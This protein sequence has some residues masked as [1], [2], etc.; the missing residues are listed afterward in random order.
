[1]IFPLDS[2]CQAVEKG[3]G[4]QEGKLFPI[5]NSFRIVMKAFIFI[6]THL[7]SL[8]LVSMFSFT[9]SETGA[10]RVLS[11]KSNNK[12]LRISA[13]ENTSGLSGYPN[14]TSYLKD[15]AE[16]KTTT[17]LLCPG[18]D[19][20]TTEPLEL[21]ENQ[22][23]LTVTCLDPLQVCVWNAANGS[24]I[25][26]HSRDNL[27]V[28]I[29]GVT[30]ESSTKSSIIVE[31]EPLPRM[32]ILFH[33]CKWKK[34][35]GRA[36]IEIIARNATE[37]QPLP[38]AKS[39][40]NAEVNIT[41]TV[42]EFNTVTDSV[43]FNEVANLRVE[44][45]VFRENQLEN[46]VIYCASGT[47]E[48]S[49]CSMQH[50]AVKTGAV[51]V[52]NESSAMIKE[53]CGDN[54][55][56]SSLDCNGT[57]YKAN[58]NTPCSDPN[59]CD[60][61]C[62]PLDTCMSVTKV[63]TTDCY[64]TWKE[65]TS[66]LA[67]ISAGTFEL[68]AG[69][70]M[71]VVDPIVVISSK[72]L[73]IKC[74]PNG[75]HQNDCSINGGKHHFWLRNPALE[76]KFQGISFA[77]ST[78]VSIQIELDPSLNAN[79]TF[80][81]CDWS[82]N[83]GSSTMMIIPNNSSRQ[84]YRQDRMNGILAS[85]TI[86]DCYF[87]ENIATG[88]LITDESAEL[89]IKDTTFSENSAG[90][91]IIGVVGGKIVLE[92]IQLLQ[93][94]LGVG[95]IFVGLDNGTLESTGVCEKN[96]TAGNNHCKGTIYDTIGSS[97]PVCVELDLC[98]S[99]NAQGC[100]STWKDLSAAL[101]VSIAGFFEICR[102]SE[103][104]LT[105]S[106]LPIEIASDTDIQC[107]PN[108]TS[109]DEC[110]IRGGQFQFHI[111]DRAKTVVFRGIQFKEA[112]NVS[113][114]VTINPMAFSSIYFSDCH[115]E[116]NTG[117]S[118]F[119]ILPS[120]TPGRL[121]VGKNA[122][123]ANLTM[124]RS[125]FKNNDVTES[126]VSNGAVDLTIVNT[127]FSGNTAIESVIE[128]AVENSELQMVTLTENVAGRGIV[129][130][131]YGAKLMS[132]NLCGT[133]NSA[134]DLNCTGVL[135]SG[136]PSNSCL[137]GETSACQ[138]VCK[139]IEECSASP[140]GTLTIANGDEC[141]S[142]WEQLLFSLLNSGGDENFTICR[143]TTFELNETSLPL[144]VRSSDITLRCGV[145]G[146][147]ENNCTIVG[148]VQ[149]LVVIG[150]S[151]NARV[152]GI[153]F[154]GTA[155]STAVFGLGNVT[156]DAAFYDC[157]FSGHRGIAAF[158]VASSQTFDHVGLRHMEMLFSEIAHRILQLSTLP[159]KMYPAMIVR[160]NNCLFNANFVNIA[161]LANLGGKVYVENC[162]F[163]K[164][165][166]EIGGVVTI[167]SGRLSL[168]SSCFIQNKGTLAGSVLLES[169]SMLLEESEN[170]GTKN[171]ALVDCNGVIFAD[172]KTCVDFNSKE[173][174]VEI[175]GSSP[176]FS[177]TN[178]GS[179]E[180]TTCFSD[181]EIFYS[182]VFAA[183]GG[184]KFRIC[185]DTTFKLEEY[186]DSGLVPLFITASNIDI[187]CG[188]RQK[189]CRFSGGTRH[190]EFRGSV[191]NVHLRGL[192][193]TN[194]TESS[195]FASLTS[196]MEITFDDCEWIHNTGN[197]TI[198]A[199]DPSY[200]GL[201]PS[202]QT[203]DDILAGGDDSLIGG[204][205]LNYDAFSDLICNLCVF[206]ANAA[207]GAIIAI[208]GANLTLNAVHFSNNNVQGYLIVADNGMVTMTDSCLSGNAPGQGTFNGAISG[209]G[210]FA[211]NDGSMGTSNLKFD[212]DRCS[213]DEKQCYGT[214][215]D[216]STA[217]STAG[218]S[219]MIYTLC[220]NTHLVVGSTSSIHVQRK[221]TQFRCGMEG[222]S[223]GNC[224]V[225]GGVTQ[226]LITGTPTGVVFAG[227]TFTGAT[228]ASIY[229]SGELAAR[230]EI[231]DCSF[232]NNTGMASILLYN[233]NLSTSGRADQRRRHSIS[234][235]TPPATRSMSI[236]LRFCTFKGNVHDL[237]PIA[238]LSGNL[239]AKDCE[240]QGNTGV[241]GGI[242]MLFNGGMTV[243]DSCFSSNIASLSGGI[244][245]DKNSTAKEDNNYSDGNT[246]S[247]GTC[248]D[249]F[250]AVVCKS[251]GV[252]N[253]SCIDFSA[254]AC[255]AENPPTTSPTIVATSIPSFFGGEIDPT[256]ENLKCLKTSALLVAA[257]QN[258]ISEHEAEVVFHLCPNTVYKITNPFVIDRG[259]ARF[260][261]G[262]NGLLE[263]NCTISGN[264][265]HFR[266]LDKAIELSL[267]GLTMTNAGFVSIQALASSN[268]RL[269]VERC[270]FERNWGSAAVLIYNQ[271]AGEAYTDQSDLGTLSLPTSE[272]MV[273][274]FDSCQFVD[275]EAT[276][277]VVFN[278][279]GS[280][281]FIRTTFVGST[282]L[283]AAVIIG[284]FGA[285]I[286]ISTSCFVENDSSFPGSIFLASGAKLKLNQDNF[287]MTNIAGSNCSDIFSETSGSCFD[288]GTCDGFCTLFESTKC[289]VPGTD[290]A[291]PTTA[292]SMVPS[293]IAGE[294]G[295][296]ALT[297]PG[298][299]SQVLQSTSFVL[300]T[301]F[302]AFIVLLLLVV[303]G[304]AGSYFY[305]K[306]RNRRVTLET[307]DMET[308]DLMEDNNMSHEFSNGG[309]MLTAQ[310]QANHQGINDDQAFGDE[311]ANDFGEG[312]KSVQ[313][314]RGGDNRLFGRL[315]NCRA[316]ARTVSDPDVL[317]GNKH[318][319]E[320]SE[321][322]KKNGAIFNLKKTKKS[323]GL[324]LMERDPLGIGLVNPL[325]IT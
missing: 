104:L 82:G 304:G 311:D 244:L 177:P 137:R 174:R 258:E 179:S 312:Y 16:N 267:Q 265:G 61:P 35:S 231:S 150:D 155:N 97:N 213:A 282:G 145:L 6:L 230:A 136:I 38:A 259:N 274:A 221:G 143:D 164:N 149:Q 11:E 173:C 277:A 122:S 30:F 187:E 264:N 89:V 105:K 310:V 96:N 181:W 99:I 73:V 139:S 87:V 233:G 167:F 162:Q 115:W 110:T 62:V 263:D 256:N 46:S 199:I 69:S 301:A 80:S 29:E 178:L 15:R 308:K 237:A 31:V 302:I 206:E 84:N 12:D 300:S 226:F 200:L 208:N 293:N 71:E 276:T 124:L 183:K 119:S 112:T 204:R 21:P 191:T 207:S 284:R 236:N 156:S 47:V 188:S 309:R 26:I 297:G 59:I 225:H 24:H 121:L 85:I 49:N 108:G 1:V 203:T 192:V 116:A 19:Y 83:V 215:F 214:W 299:A 196:P 92:N 25:H 185:Q 217:V 39:K 240:F 234:D 44:A 228:V 322:P 32:R 50:M 321:I 36:T 247:N 113:I 134:S 169:R 273:V 245:V 189:S 219:S 278:V 120:Q 325:M 140:S 248:K 8:S 216:L 151:K 255:E 211:G 283:Q 7:W 102:G 90:K 93:N 66:A 65:L 76:L 98:A 4:K 40:S 272:S 279:G 306:K 67:N 45:S 197:A 111:K 249:L 271:D 147:R 260:Q 48:I 195:I 88:H 252:C 314:S 280:S 17:L 285:S 313:E 170:Y 229:A 235:L 28:L 289:L 257:V 117:R 270:L 210:N 224:V 223:T 320:D 125:S 290:F 13:C 324:D 75:T 286:I 243:A 316:R 161:P 127:L 172:N 10:Y 144:I 146:Q 109:T 158:I 160:F 275:N 250:S 168:A 296:T 254:A 70:V 186:V 222:R 3:E 239:D 205:V 94:I 34:N 201:S 176:S 291:Y 63:T 287:G 43:I 131:G 107:G 27:T 246:V 159:D 227:I 202:T 64:S 74:G 303:I 253:G 54:L 86:T 52:A 154:V 95:S 72:L 55:G 241:S 184:E 56:T 132:D 58:D 91:A 81:D 288:S 142:N 292:P 106:D 152:E 100:Y 261:C 319:G 148:G 23:M 57:Y 305:C 42:F 103:L 53:L 323:D 307:G 193:F 220:E 268:T 175:Q 126:V 123:L 232:V 60:S 318:Y 20:E 266:I 138:A 180:N 317:L 166:G 171:T 262:T 194:A 128:L 190:V 298:N 2:F 33:N 18:I 295:M 251:E 269:T 153:T 37:E 101:N 141:Y 238:A 182:A 294:P 209:A 135:T 198:T 165:S 41:A 77:K 5:F 114:Q 51:H 129:Y 157:E 79:V 118:A 212:S 14:I 163:K 22:N 9:E 218:N 130:V 78:N 68:C 242:V 281:Q 133:K 315:K